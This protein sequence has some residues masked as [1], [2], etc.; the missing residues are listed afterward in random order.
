M[1]AKERNTVLAIDQG[2]TGSTVLLVDT[3]SRTILAKHTI[4][5][6]QHYP[7]SGWVE[8]DP[9]EILNS[10]RGAIGVVLNESKMDPQSIKAI[11]IT[12]QRE[13]TLVWD[14]DT[15]QTIYRAIVWQDRRTAARCAELKAHASVF[16]CTGLVLDPYFSGTKV[17]WILNNVTNAKERASEGK[18]AFGTVESF[19]VYHLTGFEKHVTDTTNASRTLLFDIDRMR[20]DETICKTLGIP[21]NMLPTVVASSEVVGH[22]KNFSPL[23]DGIPIAGLC[24]DQQS[25]LFG[26]ACTESGES[27]CTYGTGAF[28][29]LHTGKQAVRSKHGLLTTV[30]LSLRN[31]GGELETTYAIEGSAFIAGAAVGWLRDG[32][33]MINRSSEVEALATS[34]ESS[35]QVSFVPALTGLGAPHWNPNARGILCGLERGTTRAHIA[36][37]ALEGIAL[38]VND[39]LSAMAED[40]AKP[41]RVLR[42]DGGAAENTFLMQ[43]QADISQVII[44]RPSSVETTALGAAYLAAMAV[45][46]L[47]LQEVREGHRIEKTFKPS[48]DQSQSTALKFKW[49]KAIE[50]VLQIAQ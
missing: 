26:Q 39:L 41:L 10:V 43:T 42:V 23:P 16:A 33:G 40:A 29:L 31:N 5:F 30:A 11:G 28:A 12:N 38:S 7:A 32:L 3:T 13:T 36:R 21:M 37:A 17:E 15:H 20:F 44:D 49:R 35:M 47:T 19:L 9:D 46:R 50:A 4:D 45:G 22:T 8:H 48:A 18:L 25:A 1:N 24:G 2:T 34:V 27:K 14:R 6:P